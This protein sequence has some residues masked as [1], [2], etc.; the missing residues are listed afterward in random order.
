MLYSSSTGSLCCL[1]FILLS[2]P[3]LESKG[4]ALQIMADQQSITANLWPSTVNIYHVMIIV[5]SGF[6]KKS[7]FINIIFIF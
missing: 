6:S 3:I 1:K 2:E 4:T 7:F 5:T